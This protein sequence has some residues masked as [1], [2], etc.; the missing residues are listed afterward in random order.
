[1]K[2]HNVNCKNVLRAIQ[3]GWHY[4]LKQVRGIKMIAP[5]VDRQRNNLNFE[6]DFNPGG[7]Q[8]TKKTVVK[9]E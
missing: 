9:G 4:N 1:M 8:T 3:V 2:L 6:A 7:W 5:S